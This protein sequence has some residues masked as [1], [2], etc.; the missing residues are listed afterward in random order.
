MLTFRMDFNERETAKTNNA[1]ETR[2]ATVPQ[3]GMIGVPQ[4]RVGVVGRPMQLVGNHTNFVQ[5]K[6]NCTRNIKIALGF[7]W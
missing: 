3:I 7:A 1:K 5:F 6:N 2:F 4:F